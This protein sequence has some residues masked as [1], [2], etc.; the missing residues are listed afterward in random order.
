MQAGEQNGQTMALPRF[1]YSESTTAVPLLKPINRLEGDYDFAH[2]LKSGERLMSP[3]A[4]VEET[5]S[6]DK[7]VPG[8]THSNGRNIFSGVARQ[9]NSGK[10]K[11]GVWGEIEAIQSHT[12]IPCAVGQ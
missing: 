4:E 8:A 7:A 1:L 3:N 2:Q 6:V 5:F 12:L 10:Y 9:T 11:W